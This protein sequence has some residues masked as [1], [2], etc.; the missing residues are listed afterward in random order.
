MLQTGVSL[1]LHETDEKLYKED[2]VEQLGKISEVMSR[3][4]PELGGRSVEDYFQAVKDQWGSSLLLSGGTGDSAR[5]S[6]LGCDPYLDIIHQG[7]IT[8]VRSGSDSVLRTDENPFI[9][10]QEIYKRLSADPFSGSCPFFAGGMGYLGYRL[11]KYSETVPC[12]SEQENGLPDLLWLFHRWYLVYD[13]FTSTFSVTGVNYQKPDS[14]PPPFRESMQLQMEC[15]ADRLI[16]VEAPGET[17]PV[18]SASFQSN[19]TREQYCRAVE[20][21]KEYI[22]AGDIYQVNL[23]QRF[24]TRFDG[25]AYELFRVLF[26]LNPSPF[27][28]FM[29]CGEFQI[30]CSSPERFL[31]RQGDRVETRPIKGT[32]PRGKNSEEENRILEELLGSEKDRAELLMIVDLLRNDLGKVCNT[33]S[34]TVEEPRR[35][36]RY[37]NV[38]HSLA[39][40]SG[41]VSSSIHPLDCLVACFPGGSVTGCP[42]IRAMEIIDEIETVPRGLYTGSL[43]YIGFDNSMDLNILIRTAV[44]QGN[45]LS[46]HVGGAI[47]ADSDPGEEFEE[48]LY[49]GA[50]LMKSLRVLEKGG[51]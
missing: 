29:Q 23:S 17:S 39:I 2:V 28:A 21:A 9:V 32:R 35:I 20:K 7:G 15:F 41:K 42:K 1:Y 48:T 37:E 50:S 14:S 51:F 12:K 22:G 34:V 46:F 11:R 3:E 27:S 8:S 6:I 36:E 49:K 13:H 38:F 43:G 5:F 45:R 25:N 16:K 31:Y 40:I 10:I 30:V 4:T 47:V 26:S 19:F 44:V 18:S 24:Q 33:G